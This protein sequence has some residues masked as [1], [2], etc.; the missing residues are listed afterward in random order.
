MSRIDVCDSCEKPFFVSE[1]GGRMPG[2]RESE[3]ISCPHCGHTF[4]ERSN[5]AFVTS[6]LSREAE[7]RWRASKKV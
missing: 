5:G 7:D 4:T 1:I 3:E 2:A 6:Q